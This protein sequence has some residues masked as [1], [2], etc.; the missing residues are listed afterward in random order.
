MMFPDGLDAFL[1]P[2]TPI[3]VSR[4][5]LNPACGQ[6]VPSSLQGGFGDFAVLGG[7]GVKNHP[8]NKSFG[9][10]LGILWMGINDVSGWV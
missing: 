8:K 10:C 1:A 4:H 3:W 7:F 9:M 2:E 6:Y 5:P